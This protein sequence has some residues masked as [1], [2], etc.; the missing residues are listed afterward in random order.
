MFYGATEAGGTADRGAVFR[1]TMNGA[2]TVLRSL[3]NVATGAA[4]PNCT[5][6]LDSNNVP[7]SATYSAGMSDPRS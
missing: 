5:L 6:P 7:F 2:C 3:G 4:F 1:V